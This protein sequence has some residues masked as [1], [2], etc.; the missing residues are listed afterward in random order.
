VGKLFPTTALRALAAR[1]RKFSKC[2]ELTE[3]GRQRLGL[4]GLDEERAIA[5]GIVLRNPNTGKKVKAVTLV[6]L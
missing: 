3:I 6:M 4:R 5:E 1:W 2:A